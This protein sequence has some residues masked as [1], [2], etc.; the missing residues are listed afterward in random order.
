[1]SASA[2]TAGA[3]RGG[4]LSVTAD[5]SSGGN[6]GSR[7]GEQRDARAGLGNGCEGCTPAAI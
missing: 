4:V 7:H 6:L 3:E 1:M 2:V 5:L